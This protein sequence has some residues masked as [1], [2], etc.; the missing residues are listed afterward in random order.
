[1]F[2]GENGEVDSAPEPSITTMKSDESDSE[3][4]TPVVDYLCCKTIRN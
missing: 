1:M 2:G 4:S 3:V